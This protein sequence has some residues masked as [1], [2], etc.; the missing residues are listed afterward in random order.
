MGHSLFSHSGSRA[1]LFVLP[2]DS[3]LP[4]CE[5]SVYTDDQ[6]Y[7]STYSETALSF[8]R[9]DVHIII[10]IKKITSGSYHLHSISSLYYEWTSLFSFLQGVSRVLLF[11]LK[12]SLSP[13]PKRAMFSFYHT[14]Y[15]QTISAVTKVLSYA[16]S[17][18]PYDSLGM[19]VTL[20]EEDSLFRE[21]ERG[22]SV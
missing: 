2:F 3:A 1:V 7:L 18:V 14:T 10:P 13:I 15:F 12:M 20:T 4:I 19:Y 8:E 21:E 9:Q 17:P 6:T 22:R 11:F 16:V 5:L